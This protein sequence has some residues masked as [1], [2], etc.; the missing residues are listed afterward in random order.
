MAFA[1]YFTFVIPCL[2][3][4]ADTYF[5]VYTKL[6][7]YKLKKHKVVFLTR[8]NLIFFSAARSI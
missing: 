4:L 1:L 3:E 8:Q 6:V 5:S 7:F 2:L